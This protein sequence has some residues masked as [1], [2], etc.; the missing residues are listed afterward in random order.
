MVTRNESGKG[1]CAR[2][3]EYFDG[4][5]VDLETWIGGA[6]DDVDPPVGNDGPFVGAVRGWRVAGA[7]NATGGLGTDVL[8]ELGADGTWGRVGMGGTA[9][10]GS[11]DKG[12]ERHAGGS[13]GKVVEGVR[14][15]RVGPDVVLEDEGAVG[16]IGDVGKDETGKKG[17]QRTWEA[18][19]GRLTPVGGRCSDRDPRGG[20]GS[21]GS[22]RRP[23]LDRRGCAVEGPARSRVCRGS[24]VGCPV[25]G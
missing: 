22:V 11:C 25:R 19:E 24:R 15:R 4:A 8:P 20:R 3:F 12:V 6:F 18:G 17:E 2:V 23:G 13:E 5:R 10:C 16:S 7:E 21:G 14:E 1:R 9:R